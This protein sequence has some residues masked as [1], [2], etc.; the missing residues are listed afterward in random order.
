ME[1]ARRTFDSQQ[2]QES[3]NERIELGKLGLLLLSPRDATAQA[4]E[5]SFLEK[6][7]LKSK[8]KVVNAWNNVKYGMTIYDKAC[9]T[10]LQ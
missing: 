3:K 7:K 2:S 5:D 6:A 8:A 9:L 10:S 4:E 1:R